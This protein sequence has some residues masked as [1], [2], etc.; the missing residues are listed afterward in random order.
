MLRAV[1][2]AVFGTHRLIAHSH[3]QSDHLILIVSDL[4]VNNLCLFP[5]AT[6]NGREALNFGKT[7]TVTDEKHA[8]DCPQCKLAYAVQ[9]TI[10]QMWSNKYS[11]VNLDAIMDAI[12]ELYNREKNPNIEKFTTN[13]QQDAQEFADFIL[14]T[15][16]HAYKEDHP[17]APQDKRKHPG[18]NDP[19]EPKMIK[20]VD[21][22]INDSI[23][24]RV[25]GFHTGSRNTCDASQHV[26][27]QTL[28]QY[29]SQCAL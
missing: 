6:T 12:R 25:F 27:N 13:T 11:T 10:I 24:K 15:M 28:L 21:S 22:N 16:H 17:Q 3:P 9:L 18:K 23:I 7:V 26:C 19:K 5:T 20:E 2:H 1:I 8:D 4:I 29:L 14:D